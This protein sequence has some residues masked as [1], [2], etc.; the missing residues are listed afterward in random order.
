MVNY[1]SIYDSFL[2]CYFIQL[3]LTVS[4]L[5]S[6]ETNIEI[7]FCICVSLSISFSCS[8]FFSLSLFLSLALSI[9]HTH[10]IHTSLILTLF[11]FLS[12][13]LFANL[14]L[15][16]SKFGIITDKFCISP[17]LSICVLCFF[18]LN[19]CSAN[20]FLSLSLFISVLFPFIFHS[21]IFFFFSAFTPKNQ[22]III[23]EN[24]SWQCSQWG[25]NNLLFSISYKSICNNRYFC[26]RIVLLLMATKIPNTINEH[27][28][29]YYKFPKIMNAVLWDSSEL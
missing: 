28:R 27:Y 7:T 2:N 20:W 17:F 21:L 16:L 12:M 14:S 4:H 13:L 26:N 5:Q 10:F 6:W 18:A 11:L 8:L 23:F 25:W 19:Y 24:K 29:K 9:S 22:N 1:F 3:S 15:P